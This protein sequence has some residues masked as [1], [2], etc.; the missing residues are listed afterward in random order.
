MKNNLSPFAASIASGLEEAITHAKGGHVPGVRITEVLDVK[1]IRTK[2][3]M[4]Q[5][6]FAETYH[7]S[8]GTVKGWEQKRRSIDSTAAALLRT[9]DCYP[10]HVREAQKKLVRDT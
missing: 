3:G 7:I 9:I 4:T 2:L 6:Q 8:A 10:E 1:R 5:E